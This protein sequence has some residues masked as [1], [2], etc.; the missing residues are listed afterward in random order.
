MSFHSNQSGQ[1]LVESAIILPIFVL[2]VFGFLQLSISISEKQKLA[3][4]TNYA[5]QVGS[6][7]NNDEKISGAINE[8]YE[9]FEVSLNLKNKSATTG[10]EILSESRRYN[11]ILTIQLTKQFPLQ[12][13]F[14]S[15]SFLNLEATSS[16]RIL[17]NTTT[18]PYV[19]E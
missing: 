18:T 1:A 17:C 16:A 14:I 6:L 4:V 15:L 3:Y 2:I 5:T 9:L 7:T 13:P 19:C 10:N 12:I 8:F 11:D